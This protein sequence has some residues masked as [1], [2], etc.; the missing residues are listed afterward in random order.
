MSKFELD[1]MA[2]VLDT[3][4]AIG[5]CDFY[6]KLLGWTRIP[7]QQDDEWIVIVNEKIALV[8][9]QVDDYQRPVWPEEPGRQQQMMH[10]DFYVEDPEAA[11]EHAL[12]CG[13]VISPVQGGDHWK[14]LL[15]PAGH[16]F[17]IIPKRND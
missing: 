13:A 9:Q 4:D 3:D 15:D 12:E 14:V 6:A 8:F 17:C 7:Y 11:I 5:L 16:P 2:T 1:A 10:L